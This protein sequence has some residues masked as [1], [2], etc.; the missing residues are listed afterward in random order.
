MDAQAAHWIE[1]A[2]CSRPRRA[3]MAQPWSVGPG[4]ATEVEVASVQRRRV[5]RLLLFSFATLWLGAS[6]AASPQQKVL[7]H[8]KAAEDHFGLVV[9]VSGDSA[10]VGAQGQDERGSG[11]GA[12]YVYRFDGTGWSEEAKLLASDGAPSHVFGRTVA[13]SGDV[14]VVGAPVHDHAGESSGA[15]YVFRHDG[16]SW[17]EEARLVADDAEPT[18]FFGLALAVSGN[19]VLVAAPDKADAGFSWAGA[20]YLFRHDGLGW[21][22]EA[23]LTASDP[24]QSHAFG[25]SVSLTGDV[26]VLGA[27]DFEPRDDAGAVYVFRFDGLD[28][29]EEAKL[30]PAD[31]EA[32]TRFGNSV[33]VS[34][35]A[36]LVGARWDST[37]GIGAGAAYVFRHDG[38]AWQ[39]E[40][41]LF[42]SDAFSPASFGTGVAVLGDRALVGAIE[43]LHEGRAGG[44][45]YVF[46]HDGMGWVEQ[47]KLVAHD[48]ASRDLLGY[49]V[50]L[51]GTVALAG[52]HRDEEAGL[53]TGAAYFFDFAPCDP[54]AIPE[55]SRPGL[56]P[57]QGAFQVGRTRRG[58]R[59]SWQGSYHEVGIHVGTLDALRGGTHD[60]AASSA[61]GLRG[62]EFELRDAT[63]PRAY[64][65]VV[66]SGCD[67]RAEGPYGED[68]AGRPRPS[69]TELGLPTCP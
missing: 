25:R 23:K 44:A 59:L 61:C 1:S 18:D 31:P 62:T 64:F 50:S 33:S 42:G 15:A 19:L 38:M 4:Q 7:A 13:L 17:R 39:Q 51:S 2:P 67:P 53:L 29:T 24:S 55:I 40:A 16:S 58:L 10:I 63:P 66:A 21:S 56:S 49:T 57:G 6:V 48:A 26:A 22:Q 41:K 8:D 68:S 36:I 47:T 45:V 65:L 3:K 9:S 11:S 5:P 69:A 60:H 37:R 27:R 28:W 43:A 12:A 54:G 34:G 20:A 32:G 30:V 46:E 35:E 52:A 14:A